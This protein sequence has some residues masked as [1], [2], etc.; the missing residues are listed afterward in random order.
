MWRAEK[1][2]CIATSSWLNPRDCRHD[3]SNS[4]TDSPIISNQQSAISNQQSAI[5]N[6]QSAIGNQQSAIGNRQSISNR[7]S[8]IGN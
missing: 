8:A 4:P 6:R 1:P 7:Q 2:A 5:S 3:R